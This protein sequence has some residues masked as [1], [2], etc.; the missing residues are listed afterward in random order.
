MRS[1]ARCT[2][3]ERLIRFD[4]VLTAFQ[5]SVIRGIIQIVDVRWECQL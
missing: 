1:Q 4:R 2:R 3:L 5:Q